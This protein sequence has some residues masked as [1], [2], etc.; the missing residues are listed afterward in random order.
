[1]HQVQLT[2]EK[3][4]DLLL[5]LEFQDVSKATPSRRVFRHD[6]TDTLLAFA[7]YPPGTHVREADLIATQQQLDYRGLLGESEFDR[8]V[9]VAT[10]ASA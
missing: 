9:E 8:Q 10:E 1:M 4:F 5:R 2:Y 7:A 3:L 6:A